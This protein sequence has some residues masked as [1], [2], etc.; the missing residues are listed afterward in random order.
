VL[1]RVLIEGIWLQKRCSVVREGRDGR[2]GKEA[3]IEL[4]DR[5]S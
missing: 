1:G 4:L 3:R 2:V 5:S